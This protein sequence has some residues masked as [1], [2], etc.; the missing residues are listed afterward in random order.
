[1]ERW[2][3]IV[4]QAIVSEASANTVTVNYLS[5]HYSSN[6]TLLVPDAIITFVRWQIYFP[7]FPI[8]SPGACW[9]VIAPIGFSLL[10]LFRDARDSIV[11]M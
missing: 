2:E 9:D 1:M 4:L 10:V 11:R 6:P 7:V 3:R 5:S 8:A